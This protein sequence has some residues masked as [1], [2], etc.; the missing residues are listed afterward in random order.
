METPETDTTQT[1]VAQTE[2]GP[3]K[4]KFKIVNLDGDMTGFWLKVKTS[5]K[6][7]VLRRAAKADQKSLDDVTAMIANFCLEWN[8]TDDNGQP[9]PQPFGS[10]EAFDE[11]ESDQF[12][13]VATA[14]TSVL[15]EMMDGAT[16][17]GG[18][19]N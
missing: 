19:K 11:L 5:V 17:A 3:P 13:A 1:S 9:L 8:L 7:G 6:W 15:S 4:P 16:G 10:I 2:G 12:T 14:V 18:Q